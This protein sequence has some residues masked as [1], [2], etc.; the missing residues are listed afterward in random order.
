MFDW[1]NEYV[2]DDF[3]L[4]TPKSLENKVKPA[5]IQKVADAAKKVLEKRVPFTDV[6]MNNPEQGSLNNLVST[7]LENFENFLE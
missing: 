7:P 5:Y 6:D 3:G 1:K 2:H 4:I